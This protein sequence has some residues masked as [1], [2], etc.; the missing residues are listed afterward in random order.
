M[1]TLPDPRVTISTT[2]RGSVTIDGTESALQAATP[3][4]ARDAAIL[5]LLGQARRVG[6]PVLAGVL[7][8]AMDPPV[9]AWGELSILVDPDGTVRVGEHGAAP[10]VPA[11]PWLGSDEP[12]EADPVA[13]E[14]MASAV[15]DV[16]WSTV[17]RTPAPPRQVV[18]LEVDGNEPVVV[19]G[20]AICGRH[21]LRASLEDTAALQV[22]EDPSL[23]L[24]KTHLR[25][26]WVGSEP[27]VTDLHSGNGTTLTRPGIPS[28][29]LR[30]GMPTGIADGDVLTVCDWSATVRLPR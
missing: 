16:A 20:T 3:G 15:D 8:P 9:A 21:P 25:I 10:Q 14:P 5:A 4:A 11:E 6:Q 26:E 7:D 30:P 27:T 29:V 12:I 22:L 24:S 18:L 19:A 2:G 13:D 17:L 28:A 23:S 1:S